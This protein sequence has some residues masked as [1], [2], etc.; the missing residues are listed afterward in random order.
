MTSKDYS[1]EVIDAET[2]LVKIT[3]KK[4]FTG[5]IVAYVQ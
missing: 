5:S 1:I 3:G 4:N 2:G